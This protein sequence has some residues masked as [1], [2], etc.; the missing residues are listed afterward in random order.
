M[1][2]GGRHFERALGLFLSLDLAEID[3]V[4]AGD[5]EHLAEV[6]PRRWNLTELLEELE[7]LAQR[8]D[9]QHGHALADHR[10]LRGVLTRQHDPG[11]S[12][13]ARQDRTRQRALDSLHAAVQ[14]QLAEHYKIAHPRALLH[15]AVGGQYPERHR[16]VEGRALLAN[17]GGR[18]VDGDSAIG[19]FEAGIAQRRLHPV[20]GFA[21]RA[22][23]QPDHPK[24]GHPR[25]DIDFDLDP[26]GIDA[27]ES[28]GEY[29]AE[30][31]PSIRAASRLALSERLLT[32]GHYCRMK[33]KRRE[34]EEEETYETS[35]R[36]QTSHSE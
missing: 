36:F 4:T 17:I 24:I 28:A 35:E 22:L 26:E 1:T 2:A 29:A 5:V 7:R 15:H 10:G 16:Q 18:Q 33:R 6:H 14:R 32:V 11:Q 31:I 25:A 13:S 30:Q 23:G 19:K 3:R 12:T 20:E 8:I 21:H 9:P 34:R 27:G